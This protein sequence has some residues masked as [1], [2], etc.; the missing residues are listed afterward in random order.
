MTDYNISCDALILGLS[1][2]TIERYC[3]Q[4]KIKIDAQNM[5]ELIDKAINK[6]Y[7]NTLPDKLFNQQL[8]LALYED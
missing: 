1:H 6:G 2:R 8:S 3:N 4:L 5:H 7:F